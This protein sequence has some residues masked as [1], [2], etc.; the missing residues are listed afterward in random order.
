[1][2]RI[3]YFIP[4]DLIQYVILRFVSYFELDYILPCFRL[5]P[6]EI[7]LIKY[8]IYKQRIQIT[9][10]Y[11]RTIYTID[12]KRHRLDGPAVETT[13][14]NKEWWANDE[15][16]R[17]NDLPAVE[18]AN[19]YKAWYINGERHRSNGPAIEWA[20]GSKEWHINGE[21]HRTDGPA[22]IKSNGDKEYWLNGVQV[23]KL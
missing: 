7:A 2:S 17:D 13:D 9:K 19:G 21:L 12:G 18:Y 4:I 11:G 22:V 8:K 15:K 6:K 5:T 10:Q 14:G 23:H 3:N 16:H 1:M 20:D